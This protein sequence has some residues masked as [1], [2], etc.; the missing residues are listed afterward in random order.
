MSS[1]YKKMRDELPQQIQP[2][3][4]SSLFDP[5]IPKPMPTDPASPDLPST[6]A[7][8]TEPAESSG[9]EPATASESPQD[10]NPPIQLTIVNV[11]EKRVAQGTGMRPSRHRQLKELA[12]HEDRDNWLIVDDA[13]EEYVVRHYGKQFK[14]RAMGR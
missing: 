6:P 4:S 11:D 10:S 12:F 9:L 1:N 7:L 2:R 13:I 3:F 5:G 14:R 8:P